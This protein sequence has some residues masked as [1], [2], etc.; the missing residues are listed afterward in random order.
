[1]NFHSSLSLSLFLLSSCPIDTLRKPFL[2]L[3]TWNHPAGGSTA[4]G[5]LAA[6]GIS[7]RKWLLEPRGNGLTVR[8]FP[9]DPRPRCRS[10]RLGSTQGSGA[11]G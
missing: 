3:V 10:G 4:S 5:C 1:M 2:V 7:S 11:C 9:W 6:G 8:A